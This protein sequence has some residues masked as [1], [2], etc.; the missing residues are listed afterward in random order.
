MAIGFPPIIPLDRVVPD[1]NA[2]FQRFGIGDTQLFGRPLLTTVPDYLPS[3]PGWAPS[4]QPAAP[5]LPAGYTAKAVTAPAE[6]AAAVPGKLVDL[7]G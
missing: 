4:S 5:A 7:V 3:R 6:K 2:R 1:P